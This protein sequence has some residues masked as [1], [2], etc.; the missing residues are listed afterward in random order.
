MKTKK[1]ALVAHDGS[2]VA[3]VEVHSIHVEGHKFRV[4]PHVIVHGDRAFV[5]KNG[6]Y[7]EEP[8]FFTKEDDHG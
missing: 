3:K 6:I 7:G 4:A 2:V 1:V 5:R 8:T